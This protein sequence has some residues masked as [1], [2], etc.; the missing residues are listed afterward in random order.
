MMLE[1]SSGALLAND[2]LV[3]YTVSDLPFGGVGKHSRLCTILKFFFFLIE[4]Q[5]FYGNPQQVTAGPVA[6]MANT[7]LIS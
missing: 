5:T 7:H 4:S 3:H 6:T 1:T 2:C